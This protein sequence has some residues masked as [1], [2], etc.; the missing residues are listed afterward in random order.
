LRVRLVAD[1]ES[2]G[3]AKATGT[4]STAAWLAGTTRMAP[5]AATGIVK[6]GQALAEWTD[7]ADAL[8]LGR[9]STAHAKV[10]VGFFAHLARRCAA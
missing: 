1:L 9:I 8:K 6:L 3:T 4:G 10:I 5:G 7:T 2:R